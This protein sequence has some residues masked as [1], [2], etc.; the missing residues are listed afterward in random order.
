MGILP[1]L[2]MHEPLQRTSEDCLR[3]SLEMPMDLLIWLDQVKGEL[4]L[5]SRGALVVRLLQE[6]RGEAEITAD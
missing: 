2:V 6:I 4:G 1:S 5:R 3:V